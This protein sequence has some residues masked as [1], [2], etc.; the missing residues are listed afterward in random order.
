M[1]FK[2]FKYNDEPVDVVRKDIIDRA[3]FRITIYKFSTAEKLLNSYFQKNE[4]MSLRQKCN[5]ILQSVQILENSEHTNFIAVFQNK[6]DDKV[7][8]LITYGNSE[9]RG[10]NILRFAFD[11]VRKD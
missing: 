11:V 6:N 7:A 2:I 10:S 5:Q 1:K 9:L 8:S 3:R 4:N